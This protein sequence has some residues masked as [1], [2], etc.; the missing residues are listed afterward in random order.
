M[1]S[2]IFKKKYPVLDK[3]DL[4]ILNFKNNLINKGHNITER[5]FLE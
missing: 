2:I 1:V 3:T 5:V 4:N